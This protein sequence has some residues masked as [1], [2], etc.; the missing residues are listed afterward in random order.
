CKDDLG[1]RLGRPLSLQGAACSRYRSLRL[2]KRLAGLRGGGSGE[3]VSL[4]LHLP[5]RASLE[6]GSPDWI[7]SL[8]MALLARNTTRACMFTFHSAASALTWV[9]LPNR[10]FYID[11]D[12]L[13]RLLAY[14][15]RSG[16]QIVTIDEMLDRLE[17]P[18]GRKRL[19]NFSI[20]DCYV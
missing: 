16:W 13:A 3:H 1:H 14:L 8:D 6:R 2:R 15:I 11:L 5:G 17:G 18:G 10:N 12:F 7:S 4:S 19:V 9:T 20:D